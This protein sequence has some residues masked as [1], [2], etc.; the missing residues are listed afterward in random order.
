MLKGMANAVSKGAVE[1]DTSGVFRA[2]ADPTRLKV[3]E[4]VLREEMT[5]N[6]LTSR[7]CVTQ[8]A[9]SQHLAVLKR[10]RLVK[11]RRDGRQIYYRPDATG[12]KPMMSWIHEYQ[13]F[14]QERMPRLKNLLKEMKDE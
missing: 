1:D 2:L 3:F 5:V 10:C 12:M 14:W 11:A 6:E 7:F 4:T 8:P 9:I 13:A